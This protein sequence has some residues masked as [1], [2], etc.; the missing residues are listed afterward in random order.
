MDHKIN[1]MYEPQT[2]CTMYNLSHSSCIVILFDMFQYIVFEGMYLYVLHKARNKMLTSIQVQ[3]ASHSPHPTSASAATF[4][5]VTWN[6]IG[7][8]S[9]NTWVAARSIFCI[10]LRSTRAVEVWS[11][12]NRWTLKANGESGSLRG[13]LRGSSVEGTGLDCPKQ[14]HYDLIIDWQTGLNP[15]SSCIICVNHL[16]AIS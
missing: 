2:E 15:A 7:H 10:S 9:F 14:A 16:E 4:I 12:D 6:A 8:N 3:P 11:Q 13:V 5:P 1:W